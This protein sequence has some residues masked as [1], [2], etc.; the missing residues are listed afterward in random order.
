MPWVKLKILPKWNV[1]DSCRVLWKNGCSLVSSLFCLLFWP[2]IVSSLCQKHNSLSSDLRKGLH[3][4]KS[5]NSESLLD[6]R[7]TYQQQPFFQ[8]LFLIEN[9]PFFENLFL[10]WKRGKQTFVCA[11]CACVKLPRT[12]FTG[13]PFS[14][15][16]NGI[17]NKLDKSW[18]TRQN[19]QKVNPYVFGRTW[20]L[21]HH[22]FSEK[23]H[24][25]AGGENWVSSRN[26]K[27]RDVKILLQEPTAAA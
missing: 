7:T 9:K 12:V 23:Y 16:W 14:E 8:T 13:L 18:K 3:S 24:P 26:G 5:T 21:F 2:L 19:F 27:S 1:F 15:S 10:I 11:G 20:G 4:T 25:G 22:L 17:S 6:W